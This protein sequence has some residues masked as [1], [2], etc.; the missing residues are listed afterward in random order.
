MNTSQPTPRSRRSARAATQPRQRIATRCARRASD[1]AA[2]TTRET[3]D[4]ATPPAD[5]HD[6]DL[7]AWESDGGAAV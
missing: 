3:V 4:A 7:H 1:D 5:A 6:L 2:V